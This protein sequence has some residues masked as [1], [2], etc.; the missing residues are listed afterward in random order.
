MC[1][2]FLAGL[3]GEGAF[4]ILGRRGPHLVELAV[5]TGELDLVG[6]RFPTV[7]DVLPVLTGTI[8]ADPYDL[9]H[10]CLQYY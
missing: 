2:G 1:A 10:H 9:Y 6:H 7:V 3:A 5:R 4:L 8:V